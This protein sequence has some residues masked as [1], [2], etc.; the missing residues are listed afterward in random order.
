MNMDHWRNGN[1][2]V[3][4]EVLKENRV[5]CVYIKSKAVI[6]IRALRNVFIEI[7]YYLSPSCHALCLGSRCVCLLPV[8]Q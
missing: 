8:V 1:R 7:L 6:G 5:L 2:Q 3:K 4:T